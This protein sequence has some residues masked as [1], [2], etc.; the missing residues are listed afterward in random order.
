MDGYDKKVNNFTTDW[1]DGMAFNV[2]MH[3]NK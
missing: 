3:R 2:I 1:S